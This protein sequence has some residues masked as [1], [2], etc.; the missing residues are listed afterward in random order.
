MVEG[1]KEVRT[2]IW[3]FDPATSESS[4]PPETLFVLLI[5]HSFYSHHIHLGETAFD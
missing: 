5:T 2:E 4:P 1:Y 3:D